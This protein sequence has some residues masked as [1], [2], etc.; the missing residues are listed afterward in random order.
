MKR[1]GRHRLDDRL[2]LEN[3]SVAISD[4]SSPYDLAVT[5][6]NAFKC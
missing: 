4:Q 6:K 1:F 5:F 2:L 3:G